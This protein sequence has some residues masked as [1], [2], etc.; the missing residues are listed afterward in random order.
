MVASPVSV[1]DDDDMSHG[2]RQ[3]QRGTSNLG[4]NPAPGGHWH[5]GHAPRYTQTYC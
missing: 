1:E 2:D 5:T 3:V 4:T